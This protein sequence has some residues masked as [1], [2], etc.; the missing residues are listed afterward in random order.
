MSPWW[1]GGALSVGPRGLRLGS[2]DVVELA[3]S[4][5]TP[6]YLYDH[7][8]LRTNVAR[9]RAALSRFREQRI[10]YA[11]KANRFAPLVRLLRAEGVGI[12]ACAPAEVA[13]AR[14]LGFRAADISVTASSL[15]NADL[16]AFAQAGVHVTL[17]HV[18]TIRRYGALVPPGTAI[19]LRID[20]GVHAGYGARTDYSGGKLGLAS[21]DV[22][23]AAIAAREANL[24][25]DTL[26]MHLGWGL[27]A[28]DLPAF[29]RALEALS[30]WAGDLPAVRCIN[31]GGGLGARLRAADQPLELEAW[32]SAIAQR[33]GDDFSVACEPGTYLVSDAGILVARVTTA[34]DKRGEH[35]VGLD[36]GQATNVYAAHYGLELEIV[37]V[38]D[39][40]AHARRPT[41][42]AGNIN[43]AGDVFARG[44]MLPDLHEG[45]LV[46]LLPAGAYG[47][48]MASDHCLRGSF[49]EHLV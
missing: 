42:V 7:A 27:R 13:L 12:D 18:G 34:W 48:S 16:H 32:A 37:P 26:H 21:E 20:P 41:N 15:S 17:D 33:F 35:W 46:A 25:I 24:R 14:E 36:C 1:L 29:Q 9:L 19:G 44:R 5:G 28:E 2:V 39:P 30:V 6:A 22:A 11:L 45:D 31:V 49:A 4:L 23:A 10:Y 3:E 38:A 8:R 43:E 40:L 47:S